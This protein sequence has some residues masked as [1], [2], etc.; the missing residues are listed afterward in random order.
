MRGLQAAALDR[1]H[2]HRGEPRARRLHL[3]HRAEQRLE[4]RRGRHRDRR[5]A[6]RLDL[7]QAG[8]GEP[9]QRLAH[10]RARHA[11]TLRE[12]A[13]VE[14]Q[15]RREF[16]G[17]HALG[18]GLRELIRSRRPFD[19]DVLQGPIPIRGKPGSWAGLAQNISMQNHHMG[20]QFC[21]SAYILSL[22]YAVLRGLENSADPTFRALRTLRIRAGALRE[23]RRWFAPGIDE[24]QGVAK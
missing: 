2:A 18:D 20:I 24:P 11:V 13:L 7:D 10:R 19:F 9:P 23:G 21:R 8:R 22:V 5:A 17:E 14:P 3:R 16:A 1:R 12:H 15:P 4:L 6:P